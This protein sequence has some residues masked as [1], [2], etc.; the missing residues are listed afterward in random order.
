MAGRVVGFAVL[1]G[2]PEDAY[3]GSGQDTHRVGVLAAALTS[4][5][6]DDG[7]PDAGMSGIPMD[8]YSTDGMRAALDAVRE[9]T[10]SETVD[11]LAVCL[12]GALAAMTAA[13]T[14][15]P[16]GNFTSFFFVY[17]GNVSRRVAWVGAFYYGCLVYRSQS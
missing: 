2:S 8:D 15:R 7:G 6:V 1:P 11:I 5:V 4:L 9:I 3:P 16:G 14:M 12:G 13:Q 10:G 17:F